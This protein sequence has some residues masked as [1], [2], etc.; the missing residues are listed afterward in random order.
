[1]TDSNR[2][3]P[4]SPFVERWID[5]FPT[6]GKRSGAY[7]EGGAYDVHPYMLLNYLGQY[8]DVSTLA[9][10]LGHTMHSYYSNTRQPYA[11]ANYPTFDPNEY[12]K[13]PK[14]E[15]VRLKNVAVTDVYEPGSVFKIVAAAGALQEGLVS[16]ASRFNCTNDHIEYRGRVLK[17]VPKR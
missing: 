3:N 2:P 14:D 6:T 8:N 10:E 11:L 16:P 5:F 15:M 9:H 13:V 7:S 12:N 17:L 1:M 4:T